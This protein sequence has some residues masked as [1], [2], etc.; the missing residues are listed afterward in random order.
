MFGR[1]LQP[2]CSHSRLGRVPGT[3]SPCGCAGAPPSLG[4]MSPWTCPGCPAHLAPNQ[5]AKPPWRPLQQGVRYFAH[6]PGGPPPRRREALGFGHPPPGNS[7]DGA[8]G[9]APCCPRRGVRRACAYDGGGGVGLGVKGDTWWWSCPWCW[10]RCLVWWD[11]GCG[12][13]G[14][15]LAWRWMAGRAEAG[16]RARTAF[17]G[18]GEARWR[19]AGAEGRQAGARREA[20]E[21]AEARRGAHARRAARGSRR[22]RRSTAWMIADRAC[23]D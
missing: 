10:R 18:A 15:V 17:G 12:L 19:R 1:R 5:S 9:A 11:G 6:F 13:L 2:G 14:G 22:A 16:G 20:S 21:Q 8:Y 7:G 4:I 23:A 3:C